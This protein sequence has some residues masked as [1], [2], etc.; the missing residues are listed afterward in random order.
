MEKWK[1][2]NIILRNSD[3]HQYLERVQEVEDLAKSVKKEV[4]NIYERTWR[5]IHKETKKDKFGKWEE[6]E[7]LLKMALQILEDE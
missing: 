2:E 6:V 5:N 7:N 4:N 3:E 1:R